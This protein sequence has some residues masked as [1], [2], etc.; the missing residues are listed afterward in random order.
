MWE[1]KGVPGHKMVLGIP[2]F[3]RSYRLEDPAISMPGAPAVGPGSD[4][5]DG[6]PLKHVICFNIYNKGISSYFSYS[7][8]IHIFVCFNHK[9][10]FRLHFVIFLCIALPSHS[11][12]FKWKLHSIPKSTLSC[13]R[14]WMDWIWQPEEC[15]EQGMCDTYRETQSWEAMNTWSLPLYAL[16]F[17]WFQI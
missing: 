11:K 9:T 2:F 5:G 13:S 6:I 7:Q 15:Y 8:L 12:W 3:G 1:N 14:R 17:L 10:Y 4:N 16:Q